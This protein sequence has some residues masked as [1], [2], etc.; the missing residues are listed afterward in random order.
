MGHGVSQPRMRWA[1]GY[2]SAQRYRW[3]NWNLKGLS[4]HICAASTASG[5]PGI[6]PG[7]FEATLLALY[8][9]LCLFYG[10]AG[11]WPSAHPFGPYLALP[12]SVSIWL[13]TACSPQCQY[14]QVLP[15]LLIGF[16]ELAGDCSLP[17]LPKSWHSICLR[18]DPPWTCP[19]SHSF[20]VLLCLW[21]SLVKF[22]SRRPMKLGCIWWELGQDISQSLA[23]GCS[24]GMLDQMGEAK[25][26]PGHGAKVHQV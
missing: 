6:K 19:K 7:S 1:W 10:Y 2:Y 9:L 21:A 26:E 14:P 15:L 12:F 17:R 16:W 5:E 25:S 20:R 18:S 8:F 24:T 22:A 11:L 13:L 23:K 3:R 4:A